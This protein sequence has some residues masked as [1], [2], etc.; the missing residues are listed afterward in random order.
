MA[1]AVDTSRRESEHRTSVRAPSI[2]IATG[3]S[4]LSGPATQRRI[5]VVPDSEN[6]T[7]GVRNSLRFAGL[8]GKRGNIKKKA[9]GVH[10]VQTGDLL[11]KHAPDPAV[12]DFWIALRTAAEAAACSLHLVAGNH[13]LEIWR[14]LQSGES[15]G[16]R[17]REQRMV[18]EL[19]RTMSLFHV[20][21]SMLFIHGYPTVKLLRHVQAYRAGTGKDLNDYNA[22]CFRPA[23][24][25]PK[26]LARYAYPRRQ[27]GRRCLLHEVSD[28]ARY[29]R[30]HGAEVAALL[31]DLGIDLLIHGHRPERSGVQNDFECSRWLP[32]IRMI[33]NDVQLRVLG[34]GATA[35]SQVENGSTELRFVNRVVASSAHRSEVRKMLRAPDRQPPACAESGTPVKIA[36]L[37]RDSGW[38]LPARGQ[39]ARASTG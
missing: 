10:I 11:R 21:G 13:E 23:L 30:R 32:G 5:L 26:Q 7:Q 14:R 35:I 28:P 19:I 4:R 9:C 37:T 1:L 33:S 27:A 16:L 38:R 31:G 39:A 15:L 2:G 25:D 20:E 17:R 18:R 29:Y 8:L 3:P 22:D 34:L 12:V 24:D 6:D 36:A